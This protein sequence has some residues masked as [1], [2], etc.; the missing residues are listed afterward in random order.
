MPAVSERLMIKVHIILLSVFI[1]SSLVI[2]SSAFTR[3]EWGT[4]RNYG[5]VAGF[6]YDFRVVCAPYSEAKSKMAEINKWLG[7]DSY[8][9]PRFVVTNITIEINGANIDIPEVTFTD[10]GN[11]IGAYG[12]SVEKEGPYLLFKL[13]GGDG[14]GSYT[15]IFVVQNEKIIKRQISEYIPQ[16]DKYGITETI[17]LINR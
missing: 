1:Y 15:A 16:T 10:L 13:K 4:G 12:M 9:P 5:E 17:D 2:A 8:D 7:E 14:A 11:P 6:Q 3:E